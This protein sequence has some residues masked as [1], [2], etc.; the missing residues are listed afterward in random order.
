MFSLSLMR[1]GS[2]PVPSMDSSSFAT[3]SSR[4]T[5]PSQLGLLPTTTHSTLTTCTHAHLLKHGD[6]NWII[7][8]MIGDSP[9]QPDGKLQTSRLNHR[10]LRDSIMFRTCKLYLRAWLFRF[11]VM[12]Q[13]DV[14]RLQWASALYV[15]QDNILV[16]LHRTNAAYSWLLIVSHT[17]RWWEPLKQVESDFD[18][19]VRGCDNLQ[20]GQCDKTHVRY[21]MEE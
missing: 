20:I 18:I 2:V 6:T 19:A 14:N 8:A 11:Q 15:L 16:W 9:T 7:L 13:T 17:F 1:I 5:R 12:Y 4:F 10:T 21:L 3:A